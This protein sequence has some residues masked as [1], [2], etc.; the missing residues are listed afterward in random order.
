[1]SVNALLPCLVCGAVLE[2]VDSNWQRP[3]G[4]PPTDPNQPYGGTEFVT[5]GHYGSTFFDSFSGEEL[6]ITVCDPCLRQRTDRL[7]WRRRETTP[8]ERY[9]P[10][11]PGG[12]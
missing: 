8:T 5:G 6:V 7:G 12:S 10:T 1:M 4:H 9:L 3:H 2:N 11:P